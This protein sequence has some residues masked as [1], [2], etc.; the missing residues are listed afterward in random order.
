MKHISPIFLFVFLFTFEGLF[1]QQ[2]QIYRTETLQI[3]QISS[4]AF[5]HIS[6]LNTDDFGK[7]G[8]NGMIVINGGEAM[9][10][11][12]PTDDEASS[13]LIGW[14]ENEQKVKVKAVLAT[15]F[16]NDC[17]GGLNAFHAIG[18]PSYGTHQ[19]ITMAKAA[20]E[21]FP[22]NGFSKKLKLEVGD[23]AVETRYF[24]EGHTRDNVVT[25]V[26]LDQVLFGG[27]LIKAQGAGLGFL[28]DANTSTWSETVSK[29][30]SNFPDIKKV[31]PGHGMIGGVDLLDYTIRMFEG[32]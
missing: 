28:G 26:P 17:V 31:I 9:I 19:T 29:V 13:E 4:N 24:G 2:T 10:F 8:C 5:V 14:L 15:H 3:E 7:V 6:Y 27:C 1:A 25:Y 32:K 12:T 18:V 21:P 16:H 30:K 20:G 23:L 11:D 22:E